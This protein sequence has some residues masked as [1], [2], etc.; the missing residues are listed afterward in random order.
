MD[1]IESE[2]RRLEGLDAHIPGYHIF[3][4]NG[5]REKYSLIPLDF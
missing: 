4:G 2:I 1:K 3:I 5:K